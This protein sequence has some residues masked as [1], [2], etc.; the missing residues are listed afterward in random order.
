[1]TGKYKWEYC[2]CPTCKDGG[3]SEPQSL[4]S[5]DPTPYAVDCRQCGLLYLTHHEYRRQLWQANARWV[6][7]VCGG[8]ASWSDE[9][10]EAAI[11]EASKPSWAM[12]ECECPCCGENTAAYDEQ[13]IIWGCSNLEC[14][15]PDDIDE[16]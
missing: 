5:M 9:E 7:P 11:E 6:C 15:G 4:M 10:H 8:T 14:P 1:M 16:L 13:G 12:K 3:T 2:Q